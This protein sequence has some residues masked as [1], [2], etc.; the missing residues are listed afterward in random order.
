MRDKMISTKGN[1]G[2]FLAAEMIMLL[3]ML[4][5]FLVG[6]VAL[7][8]EGVNTMQPAGG[9]TRL[10][11]EGTRLLDRIQAL[12]HGAQVVALRPTESERGP[13]SE[14]LLFAADL[15]GSGGTFVELE[16]GSRVI[17]RGLQVVDIFQGS[18]G[19]LIAAIW[20]DEQST[21]RVVLSDMLDPGDAP[22]FSVDYLAS[23]GRW[24]E[25]GEVPPRGLEIESMKVKVRLRSAGESG[26]FSRLIHLK[27]PALAAE[28]PSPVTK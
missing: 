26:T 14:G 12:A 9:K 19:S 4:V 11:D 3:A 22:A 16:D 5:V 25:M 23:G 10:A 15:D 13:R 21:D 6:V 17:L 1:E 27:S 20:E 8:M 18:P 24:A 7:A 28:L 2:G